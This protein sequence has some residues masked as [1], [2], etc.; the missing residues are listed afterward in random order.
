MEATRRK[1]G[2]GEDGRIV[3]PE[4]EVR[5][6]VRNGWQLV[7][8]KEGG[9]AHSSAGAARRGPAEQK[10]FGAVMGG[11]EGSRRSRRAALCPVLGVEERGDGWGG[12]T[13]P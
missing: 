8:Q 5:A 10:R 6:T 3:L 13:S 7:L 9:Q 11:W 12:R 4:T 2:L 1:A